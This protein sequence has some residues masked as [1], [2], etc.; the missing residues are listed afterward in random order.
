[1]SLAT[2]LLTLE[3]V[4]LLADCFEPILV[5]DIPA[6]AE[7]LVDH[8]LLVTS[9]INTDTLPCYAL[10]VTERGRSYVTAWVGRQERGG[11][12]TGRNFGG[13]TGSPVMGLS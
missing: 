5:L 8:G 4:Q 6:A 13:R 3:Q 2:S 12:R 9:Q 7:T 10:W 1:M 11:H